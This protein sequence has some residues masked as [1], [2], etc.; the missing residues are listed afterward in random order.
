MRRLPFTVHIC[1]ETYGNEVEYCMV[2]LQNL[3]DKLLVH[4]IAVIPNEDILVHDTGEG[5]HGETPVVDLLVLVGNPAFIA[6][7]NPVRSSKKISG[8]I[9]GPFLNLLS[10]PLNGTTSEDELEPS[11]SGKLNH[12][13]KG[14]VGQGAV[15]CG[16]DA[17]CVEVPSE[18]G[19]HGD[20]TMLE[21]G[22]PVVLHCGIRLSL[23]ES[24][25][26]EESNWSGDADNGIIDPRIEDS[27]S[28]GSL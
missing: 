9:S 21:L 7:V 18:A 19:S 26:I 15:E 17:S 6:V 23:R 2:V 3:T 1:V 4:H 12:R 27:G 22:F 20:T 24:E 5:E 13:L 25:G 11:D 8:N 14:I 16:V 28:G 10:Q